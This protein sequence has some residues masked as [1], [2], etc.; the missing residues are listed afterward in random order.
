MRVAAIQDF[1][2]PIEPGDRVM[3][4]GN[5][6][7]IG[8]GYVVDINGCDYEVV[9]A[10]AKVSKVRRSQFFFAPTSDEIEFRK[11]LIRESYSDVKLRKALKLPMP[12]AVQRGA[13]HA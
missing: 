9:T 5:Q 3:L 11:L 1:V 4:T 8:I 13:H 7:E 10:Q 6:G 12:P 2:R